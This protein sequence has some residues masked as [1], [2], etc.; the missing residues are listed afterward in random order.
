MQSCA[1]PL[2]ALKEAVERV[3]DALQ[4]WT[5]T[6]LHTFLRGALKRLLILAPLVQHFDF[7]I[8][9]EGVVVD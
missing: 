8:T 7:L 2:S 1:R 4:I 9:T 3:L 5:L 6:A